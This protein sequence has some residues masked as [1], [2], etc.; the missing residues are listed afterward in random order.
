MVKLRT[1]AY[2]LTFAAALTAMV[3]CGGK[4]KEPPK[5]A[6]TQPVVAPD[7]ELP[8]DSSPPKDAKGGPSHAP[9]GGGSSKGAEGDR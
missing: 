5:G 1:A 9:E 4:E 7:I 6:P 8:T 2:N 3:G